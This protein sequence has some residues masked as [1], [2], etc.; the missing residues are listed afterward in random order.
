[1]SYVSQQYTPL[2]PPKAQGPAGP[3]VRSDLCQF[4]RLQDHSFIRSGICPLVG[5]AG[6]EVCVSF[7]VGGADACS[8]VG[9]A[10]SWPSDGQ[11]QVKGRI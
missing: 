6:L 1:M 9:G 5:E 8:L 2:S 4:C 11:G 3:R 7:L 10:G